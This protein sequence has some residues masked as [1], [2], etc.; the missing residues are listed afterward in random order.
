MNR[1]CSKVSGDSFQS[2]ALC[3]DCARACGDGNCSWADALESIPDTKIDSLSGRVLYCPKFVP[4][5]SSQDLTEEQ[6]ED[7]HSN[8]F[9]VIGTR[10]AFC[11]PK[12]LAAY[13][14]VHSCPICEAKFDYGKERCPSCGVRLIWQYYQQRQDYRSMRNIQKGKDDTCQ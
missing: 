1:R 7:D 4:G 3:W 10:R 14:S 5:N 6:W 13:S 11:R 9:E 2:S 8:D 12:R